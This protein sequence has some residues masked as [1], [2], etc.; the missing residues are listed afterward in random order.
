[1]KTFLEEVWDIVYQIFLW[2]A[3]VVGFFIGLFFLGLTFGFMVNI[4]MVGFRF[5]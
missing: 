5:L 2:F 4:F 3:L 1:M